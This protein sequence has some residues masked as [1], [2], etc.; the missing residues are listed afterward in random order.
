MTSANGLV[1]SEWLLGAGVV[2][3]MAAGFAFV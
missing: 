3:S 2:E 1:T